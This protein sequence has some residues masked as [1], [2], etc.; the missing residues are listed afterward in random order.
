[1]TRI[2]LLG[3]PHTETTRAWSWCAYTQKTRKLADMLTSLGHQV[4]LYAGE[5]SEAN[6]AEHVTVVTQG[7]Q[8]TWFGDRDWTREVFNDFDPALPW[9]Q[10]MNARAIDAIR[11]RATAG[12][13]LGIT[14]GTSQLAVAEALPELRAVEVGIGYSGV[15]APFRVFES[16]AWAHHVAGLQ[17]ADDARFFDAV[18]PNSFEAGDFPAGGGSGEYLLYVGRFTRR[19]GVEIA[20]LAAERTGRRL[21]M[22]GQGVEHAGGGVVEGSGVAVY[23]DHIEHIGVIGPLERAAFMG[24]A[25]AVLVPTM[26]LEPFGGVAVE[27]MLTGTPVIT[28][29]WGAFTETVIDGVTGFRCRTLADFVR[30]IERAPELDRAAIRRYAL[31]RFSTDVVRHQYDRY[32]AQLA[33][34]DVGGWYE[35]DSPALSKSL[36]V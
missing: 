7:E 6:V 20:A 9:W 23:G 31:E 5:A 25:R 15:F 26:Y 33:T 19:K 16:Y 21:V 34:L 11:A 36:T 18:I 24:E 2:H 30:A 10:S 3:L 32:L 14:M 29:D 4:I 35:L 17:H 12:D 8:G 22:A 1:M 13:V 27:A 28:T